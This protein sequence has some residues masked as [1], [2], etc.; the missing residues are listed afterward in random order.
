MDGQL[1]PLQEGFKEEHGLQQRHV[2][3]SLIGSDLVRLECGCLSAD[4]GP[5]TSK[6]KRKYAMDVKGAGSPRS[7]RPLTR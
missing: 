5:T 3:G 6:A 4:G 1:H 7:R 2:H